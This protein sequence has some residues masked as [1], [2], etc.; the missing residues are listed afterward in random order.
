MLIVIVTPV[1]GSLRSFRVLA[2]SIDEVVRAFDRR[3][4]NED[5]ERVC[6]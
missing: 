5:L 4:R 3:N 6:A 1:G 2:K